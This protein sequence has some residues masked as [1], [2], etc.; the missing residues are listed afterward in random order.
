M[1]SGSQDFY[2]GPTVPPA[3]N[4][5]STFNHKRASQNPGPVQGKAL[6]GCLRYPHHPRR[7][8]ELPD[9]PRL[10]ILSKTLL[11][12]ERRCQRESLSR[13]VSA[14]LA[15]GLQPCRFNKSSIDSCADFRASVSIA[16]CKSC[17]ISEVRAS[18]SRIAIN[19]NASATDRLGFFSASST[20]LTPM[21]L[22]N[23]G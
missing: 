2:V 7:Y 15:P 13:S 16:Y 3:P 14:T 11:E 22:N 19:A 4:A 20:K 9:S 18:E 21:R 12:A 8:S 10:G 6:P 23:Q 17:N 1:I 5:Q